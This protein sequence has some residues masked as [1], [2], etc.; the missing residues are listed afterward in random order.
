MKTTMAGENRFQNDAGRYAAYLETPEGRLRS[1]LAFANLEDFLPASPDITTLRALDL[2]CG[3]GVASVCLARLGM[4]VTMV[5]VSPAMLKLAERAVAEAGLSN[6][7]LTAGGDAAQVSEISQPESFDVVLCHNVLEYV[8]DPV[9]VLRDIVRIMRNSSAILSI[10]VRSQAGEVMK[11][12]I[13]A[14]DLA[15]AEHKLTAS[16]GRESLYGGD[17]RMF[18]PDTLGAMLNEASLA[19]CARRGVRVI[20]DY[21]PAQLSRSA[22]YDRIF[23]LE[24][25]LG[26]SKEFFGVARYM[27]ILAHPRTT[28]SDAHK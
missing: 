18:T 7:V 13:Q 4:H 3:T 20:S 27:H 25:K 24:R 11:A 2:G 21:L 6:L 5:D 14:G 22:E 10:L 8:D 28:A 12:A 9:A 15:T 1:D 16:V 19:I 26:M 23:A 17:V